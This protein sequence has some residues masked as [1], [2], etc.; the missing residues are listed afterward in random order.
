MLDPQ[1]AVLTALYHRKRDEAVRLAEGA[2]LT[3]W[4]AAALGRDARV[5]ELLDGDPSLLNAMSPDGYHPLGLA[6]FFGAASTVRLLLDRGANV[7]TAATNPM[8]VQALHAAAA[9]RSVEI[10]TMLLEAGA[11]P[12]ARQ[13]VG[14]TPLMGAA[15]GGSSEMVDLLLQHGADASAVSEDGK[16][17]ADV[18]HEHGH[19]TLAERLRS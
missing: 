6:A 9:S 15:A 8:R 4:E 11:D 18:A 12:N 3:I 10:V 7:S 1:S 13:H 14:Y 17:A 16:R 5:A 19:T 2:A